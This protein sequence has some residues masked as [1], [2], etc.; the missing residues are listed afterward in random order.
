[1]IQLL[2]NILVFLLGFLVM[3]RGA[4]TFIEYVGQLGTRLG[5]NKVFVGVFLVSIGTSFPELSI[6]I[7]AAFKG[8]PSVSI[9]NVIGSNIANIGIFLGLAGFFTTLVVKKNLFTKEIPLMIFSAILF[10]LF[11]GF[12]GPNELS[13]IEGIILVTIFI[14]YIIYI[15]R[16]S[17]HLEKDPLILELKHDPRMHKK[18]SKMWLYTLLGLTGLIG[19]SSILVDAGIAIA[20]I[21]KIS[22]SIIALTAIAIGTSIPDVT[23]SLVALKK[24]ESQMAFGNIIG[25]SIFNILL[26]AGLSAS[27]I[28]LSVTPQLVQDGILMLLFSIIT[29]PFVLS[30]LKLDK[31]KSYVILGL[32]TAYLLFVLLR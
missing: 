8:S 14:G 18:T 11:I 2:I 9:G 5:L 30:N 13:R 7:F 16:S 21:L 3:I 24:G 22:E 23:A 4:D 32:Y 10:F 20:G 29:L 15:F 19:G 25:S 1:M 6:S 28:P 31:K 26:V 12:W 17:S 27:L